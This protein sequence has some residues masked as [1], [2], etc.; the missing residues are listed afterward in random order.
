MAWAFEQPI[1]CNLKIVLLA[2]ADHA[3][4]TGKAWPSLDRVA[5]KS[6]LSRRSVIRSIKSLSEKPYGLLAVIYQFDA[7]GR[8]TVSSYHLHLDLACQPAIQPSP[9]TTTPCG[10]GDSLSPRGEGDKHDKGRVTNT[11]GEGDTHGTP[12]EN[13]ILEPSE[14]NHQEEG[15]AATPPD[16]L[17]QAVGVDPKDSDSASADWI[18]AEWR[19]IPGVVQPMRLLAG[20]GLE[21]ALTVKLRAHPARAWWRDLF[22]A[23]RHSPWL[24]GESEPAPGRERF[25]ATLGWALLPRNLAKILQGDYR[26]RPGDRPSVRG[27]F[28]ARGTM[29]W[30]AQ[31]D[32]APAGQE[33]RV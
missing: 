24:I 2:L 3:N 13:L 12:K 7:S 11:T 18:L 31:G 20:H 8:Q 15:P 17:P 28:S 23:V 10:E 19:L 32:P 33:S 21:Q 1:P 30:A 26:R 5:E 6:S 16:T 29:E 4:D 14:E 9:H 27:K 25:R 22:D